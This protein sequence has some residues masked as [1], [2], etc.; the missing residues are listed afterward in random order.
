MQ[1]GEEAIQIDKILGIF[2]D[3]RKDSTRVMKYDEETDNSLYL[4]FQ[5][6]NLKANHVHVAVSIPQEPPKKISR[7]LGQFCGG[8]ANFCVYKGN[9][10]KI[11][12]NVVHRT[13]FALI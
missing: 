2:F 6:F 1:R 13:I 3:G 7:V 5:K 9:S 12:R 10:Q 4:K 8:A 11:Q